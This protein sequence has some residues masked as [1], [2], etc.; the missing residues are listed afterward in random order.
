L[1][2]KAT[3]IETFRISSAQVHLDQ[4]FLDR[5]F[6]PLVA[7]D[8]SALEGDRPELR[9]LQLHLPGLR[10]Q[11]SLVVPGPGIDPIRAAL[12]TL[13][14]TKLIRFCVQELVEG[15]FDRSPDHLAELLLH[16]GFV[17]LYN[18]SL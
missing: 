10:F 8:D 15:F 16:Q 13:C 11:P 17:D 6:A 18:P 12:I 3:R 7:L 4:R 1:T 5:A 14:L 2:P 9:H